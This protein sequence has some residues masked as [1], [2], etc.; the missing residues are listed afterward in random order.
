MEGSLSSATRRPGSLFHIREMEWLERALNGT[1][2]VGILWP[3]LWAFL[4]I[5]TNPRAGRASASG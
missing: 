5:V 3:S 2:R 1:R 4:R